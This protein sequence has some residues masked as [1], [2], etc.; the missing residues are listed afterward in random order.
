MPEIV[1]IHGIAQ[2][3]RG[4]FQ[5]ADVWL[6]GIRDGLFAAGHHD[7]AR[8]LSPEDVR[9]AFFGELFRL[10]G[11]MAAMDP[12]FIAS[13]IGAGP[14]RDLLT[15]FYDAAVASNPAL[16]E[17]AGAM[18][19]GGGECAVHACSVGPIEDVRS[20]GGAGVHQGSQAG[21][22]VPG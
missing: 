14:E 17:P 12:P 21:D 7:T 5:L 11:T 19:G 4:P 13:D 8:A 10:P 3:Y 20:G 18:S 2:Q 9:V 15:A 1:G 22:G 6:A 16:A